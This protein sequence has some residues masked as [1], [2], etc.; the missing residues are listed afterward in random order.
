MPEAPTVP[1]RAR[2]PLLALITQ[3]SLDED[4]QHV[5][6]QRAA[7][8]A[9]QGA[10]DDG[11]GGSGRRGHWVAAAVVAAFGMLVTVA[12]VQTSEGSAVAD[13][14]R[15][16]LLHQ[17]DQRR[18]QSADL[19]GQILRLRERNVGL[20]DSL[21]KATDAERTTT[22]RVDRLAAQAGF[23]P[24]SGPGVRITVD[25]A[26]NG[27]AVRAEDL[28]LLA[29]GLWEAG[30]EA[31][32]I[33]GKRLTTRS[34]LYNSGPA[35]NLNSAPPM[36]PPYVVSAIGDN[37]TLQANLLDT[38]TGLA[39][40]NTADALGFRVTPENVD[41]LDLPAATLHQPSHAVKGTAED[42]RRPDGKETA[43]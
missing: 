34:A 1:D 3:E 28:A 40:S 43:P 29:N 12:A 11:A 8:R 2:T 24:V 42:N 38:S 33:N 17:I 15:E 39:F 4:Y 10:A 30:A 18:D 31:I 14:N 22:N 36:S 23:G 16:Q 5:A 13:A 32:A 37:K 27:E 21:T 41:E 20:Q 9:R 19:Q 6:E 7:A 35:I 26:P 25:D